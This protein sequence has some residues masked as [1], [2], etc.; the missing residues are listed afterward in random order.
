[1]QCGNESSDYDLVYV[2]NRTSG[3][4]WDRLNSSQTITYN[5]TLFFLSD[6]PHTVLHLVDSDIL[7]M[8]YFELQAAFIEMIM[9]FSDT[10]EGRV[11]Y[12]R[13]IFSYKNSVNSGIVLA[14][15]ANGFEIRATELSAEVGE[16]LLE[17]YKEK[18]ERRVMPDLFS[19]DEFSV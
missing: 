9:T 12:Q 15:K 18:D 10:I 11:R 5:K 17:R 13:I 3:T 7:Q 19:I 16:R 2:G 1:M 6:S 8:D 4:V 14:G